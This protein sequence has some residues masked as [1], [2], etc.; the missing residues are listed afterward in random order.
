MYK[1]IASNKRKSWLLLILFFLLVL[2]MGFWVSQAADGGY[3]I[4]SLSGVI[5]ILYGVIGYFAG[6]KIVLAL[7]GAKEVTRENAKE[8]YNI[9]ENLC[10]T[11]GLEVPKIYLIADDSPNAFATGR[12]P[13]HASL[14]FTTG[15]VAKLNRTELEGVTSHELSHIKNYDTR[16]AFLVII[17]VGFVQILA[18]MFLRFNF[19]F[20]GRSRRRSGGAE[21]QLGMIILVVSLIFIILSPIIAKLIQLTISRR[22]EFLADASGALLTRYPE[23]LA[24]ALEKISS[25]PTPL[26]RV[27]NVTENIYISTPRKEKAGVLM[28]LFSTHP[29]IAERVAKLRE[30]ISAS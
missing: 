2:G 7:S 3:G 24:S 13:K 30:M 12:D 5:A 6:D 11:A 29:P 8:L 20:G 9:V 25:D 4:L 16:L 23:G 1:E 15:L 14:A 18:D 19:F 27:S 21:G 10:I 17:L 28:R 22:R 26:R